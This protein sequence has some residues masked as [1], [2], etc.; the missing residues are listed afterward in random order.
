[1]TSLS[2]SLVQ[3]ACL[4]VPALLLPIELPP[5]RNQVSILLRVSFSLTIRH[6]TDA[7]IIGTG[8]AGLAAA[9]HISSEYD[10]L[11]VSKEA[12]DSGSSNRAQGGIAAVSD[13]SD[14]LDSHVRDTVKAGAGL[15]DS[16]VV[17]FTVS[18]A[19]RE[20]DWLLDHHL[21]FDRTD[22]GIH[23]TQ[24]GGHSTR[25]V[26][27]VADATGRAIVSNLYEQV[28][29]ISNVEMLTNRM[30]IDIV[31]D[32]RK[33]GIPR[34]AL[35]AYVY[36][37]DS[38]HVEVI[39]AKVVIL[40]TGGASKVYLYTSNPDGSTG[41]GIAM[42]ARRGA[43]V[44]NM[45]FNQFHPT[46]LF[47]PDARSFLIS[48]A[49][50]GEGGHLTLPGGDRFMHKFD[51]RGELA[52]RDVV[53]RAID[54]EMKRLGIDCV[55]LD[56]THLSNELVETR[57]PTILEK[58]LSVGI[59][60]RKQPIP[61][62]PAAHYTCG[63]VL[64]DT[65]G[66][67]DIDG[68]YAIGETACTGLHG[69]NRLASNSLLECLV[70]ARSAAEHILSRD[71]SLPQN[72]RVIAE[73]DESQVKDSDEEV[74]LHH[75]WLE[76]RRFMWDYMGI[77]RSNKRL[78]RAANRLQLLKQEVHEYYAN[79]RV[80]SSLIEL[81]NLIHVAELMVQAAQWRRESRGLH[82]NRDYPHAQSEALPSI[83]RAEKNPI[84]VLH[85]F[86]NKRRQVA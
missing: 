13:P 15:C 62:V 26:L 33:E 9:I 2:T 39:E 37:T 36:N 61:I 1:M 14:S 81:R 40:A 55:Y 23:L 29:A 5:I 60:M 16:N 25:R 78:A 54:F 82:F 69:A 79:Y 67:T 31:V 72:A 11:L 80:N 49:V 43:R 24:E 10:V 22:E 85:P 17:E 44:A 48:E 65:N 45:E 8:A 12:F 47:H 32:S 76:L 68:L 57:F 66:C 27:H 34:R 75:N 3:V 52:S 18:R 83:Q 20:I 19:Q 73:W 77:V 42:A 28:D 71:I 63:G 70:F 21:P 53:A 51:P 46:C 7:L 58:L 6:S 56:V 4:P 74:V 35:G 64:V 50:R 38:H 30:A 59:D 84:D 41:D 86:P